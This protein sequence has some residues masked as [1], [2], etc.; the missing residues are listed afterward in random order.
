M[1]DLLLGEGQCGQRNRAAS[2]KS[3]PAH[4]VCLCAVCYSHC[5]GWGRC[6]Q[7]QS[8]LGSQWEGRTARLFVIL[9]VRLLFR[10]SVRAR[11]DPVN[12]DPICS[13]HTCAW[14]P[15]KGQST[16]RSHISYAPSTSTS[17]SPHNSP[18][19][20]PLHPLP[21]VL[22]IWKPLCNSVRILC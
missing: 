12:L 2:Y 8:C 10:Q 13:R 16:R 21:P 14:G 7:H 17:P 5:A 11:A 4:T 1:L 9:L 20:P 6:Y 3:C 15:S 22:T 18:L 19:P